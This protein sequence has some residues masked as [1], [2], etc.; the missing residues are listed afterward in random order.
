MSGLRIDQS[1]LS[2]AAPAPAY[3]VQ[4][5]PVDDS[6]VAFPHLWLSGFH[7]E[8]H[9]RQTLSPALH[10]ADVSLGVAGPA[11]FLLGVSKYA[12]VSVHFVR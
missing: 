1:L 9:Y 10:S 12:L 7:Q 3:R 11:D 5:Q 8:R 4:I 6:H 2:S